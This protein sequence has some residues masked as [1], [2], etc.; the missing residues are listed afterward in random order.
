M[1]DVLV[2]A[3]LRD[4]ELR[5]VSREVASAGRRMADALGGRLVAAALGPPGTADALADLARFG[6]DRLVAAEAEEFRLYAPDAAVRALAS[7]VQG[8][9]YGLILF[10]ATAQGKDLSP[11]LAARLGS[12]LAT[13]VTSLEVRDGRTEV[14]RPVYAGKA[15]ARLAFTQSPALVSLRPNV[16]AA[17]E[18]DG[19]GERAPLDVPDGPTRVRTLRIEGG[20]KEALDVREAAIVVAGGRGM[21]GPENWSL[22]E[23]LADALGPGTTLGASR[24]VVDAGWRPHG[25]QVGQ[26]G[27]VVSPNLYFA[28]GISGAIQHLAGMRTANVIVAVNKDPDAPIFSVANYGVVGDLFEVLPRLTEEIRELRSASG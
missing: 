17:E 14:V 22:L 21:G 24:A 16:F 10:P 12:P 7:L 9:D 6:A 27:K 4:G 13:E 15:Y 19:D 23:D 3:E 8:G 28:V 26:T 25:E 2:Y 1:A 20:E 18:R 5:P 11:R